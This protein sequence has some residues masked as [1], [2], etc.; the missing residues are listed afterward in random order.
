M[1]QP[2]I[3]LVED[4][5]AVRDATSQTLELAGCRVHACASAEAALPQFA[6]DPAAIV[7]SDIRLPGSDGRALLAALRQRDADLPVILVT[8]HGDIGMAVQA[9]QGG[10]WDFIEK[11]WSRER[12]LDAVHRALAQRSLQLENRRL[13]QSLASHDGGQLLLGDAPAMRRFKSTLAAIADTDADVLILG[14][15]GS[16]KE[17]VARA[18]HQAKPQARGHFVA[19]NCAALPESVF[20]SEMFG[21]EAGAY[22]GA[23]RRRIGKIEYADGGTLF[24]DEIEGMPLPLQAKLLRVLETRSVE[25]LGANTAIPV[26]C[27][28]VAATK[29]DLKAASDAGQF[30]ADL[31]YRLNVV[32]LHLPPLRERAD[33][34]P[35]LFAHFCARAAER[36]KR[37]VPPLPPARLASLMAARWPGNVREL[38]HAA[39]RFVLGLDD[40]AA[41]DCHS[42]PQRVEQFEA[43]AIREALRAQQG[44]V[45]AAAA[46]LGI[47][48][49]TLYDKLARYHIVPASFR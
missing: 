35:L 29:I 27:R 20:E 11:P 5:D 41:D 19:I 38:A 31:Y 4:D 1:S 44:D 22:T 2:Y 9:M 6:A 13:R 37:A 33:D 47:A 39:E 46:A 3:L 43:Q 7:I 18:L 8:G 34:I 17:L 15:T 23:S 30:R 48:R 12:L 42:L 36:F 16:G 21:A 24:L 26:R 32:T 40:G 28:V 45:A 10:A 49:K 14:E 25:R